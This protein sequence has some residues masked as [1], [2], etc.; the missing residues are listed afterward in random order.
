[1]RAVSID[2]PDELFQELQEAAEAIREDGYGPE[3]F[4]ADIVAAELASRRLPKFE[5]GPH[6]PRIQ[7]A[8]EDEIEPKDYRVVWPERTECRE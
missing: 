2:L 1:M 3:H 6:G 8:I 7:A 5:T 4:A